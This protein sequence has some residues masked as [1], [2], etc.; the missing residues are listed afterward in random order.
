MEMVSSTVFLLVQMPPLPGHSVLALLTDR[1]IL[2]E[3]LFTIVLG[4]FAY[5]FLPDCKVFL[6][7]SQSRLLRAG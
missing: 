7:K 1:L 2:T 4:V 5:A 6:T 3:G